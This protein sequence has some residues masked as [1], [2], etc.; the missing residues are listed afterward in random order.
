MKKLFPSILISI[1]SLNSY[2]VLAHNEHAKSRFVAPQG[3][4]NSNCANA[5]HPCKS[6]VYAVKKANK[7]DKIKVAQGQY[8]ITNSEELFYLKDLNVPILGGYNRLDH[9][10]NQNYAI[11]PTVLT[12]V[13]VDMAKDLRQRGFSVISDGKS[14]LNNLTLNKQPN[15]F[16]TLNQKQTPQNCVNGKAG[17]FDCNNLDLLAHIP[18]T[19]FSTNPSTANDIWGHVDLNTGKEYAIIGL[20]NGVAVVDV[21]EPT[22]PIE[23][24]TVTGLSSI[25]RDIKVYQY[26]DSELGIWQAYAYA[27]I[28][29]APD[30]VSIIDL[31]DLPNSVT[32][33]NKSAVVSTAH[34]VYISN[35][36]HTFNIALPDLTPSLQLMGTNLNGGA[37][38]NYSLANPKTLTPLTGQVYGQ[39]YTHDGASLVI[40]DARKNNICPSSNMCTIFI[41]FNEKEMK[42]WNITDPQQTSLIGIGTYNDV[43]SVNQY[44]HSGWASED[45]Q[46]IFVHDEFD[47]EKAG[48]NTT[49]RIFSIADLSNPL[50]VGQWTGSTPAID[51]NGFV[52]GNRYYMTNYERGLTVL[53]ISD[54][55]FP[56]EVGFFDTFIPS[57]NADFNGAW[58]T[59]PFLPSGN[60]LVSDFNSGLYILRDNTLNSPQGKISFTASSVNVDQGNNVTVLVQRTSAQTL[61]NTSVGYE[62]LSGSATANNDYT[63]FKGRLNWSE[64]DSSNKEIIISVAD[65]DT[66]GELAES[67]FVRLYD[68]KNGATLSSPSYIKINIAGAVNTGVVNFVN[69]ELTVDENQTTANIEVSRTGTTTGDISVT[70]TL[71]A[72]SAE[73]NTDVTSNAGSNNGELTWADGDSENKIITLTI[74]NDNL[75]ESDENFT[76]NLSSQNGSRIGSKPQSIITILDDDSNTAP[77]VTLGE[78]FQANTG[79]AINLTAT[80]A[81]AENDVLTYAWSQTF[82]NNVTLSATDSANVNFV[83]TTAGTLTF[84][85]T[86]TDSK[87][88]IATDS[89]DVN[90]IAPQPVT[91]MP[92]TSGGSYYYL[93]LLLVLVFILKPK[94]HKKRK[95]M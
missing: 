13:P 95:I 22:N 20:R 16:K 31:N 34:N 88:L 86:V 64:N 90:V 73:L 51:H 85:V 35:I 1:L 92:K 83:T 66:G 52:R 7:G 76:I 3:I 36:D 67:F 23:V 55:I 30:Q 17:S 18:L 15:N 28:D 75:D 5:L 8:A 27:T 58:G 44:V 37:F 71:T 59:Y 87:G 84:L 2:N 26:Y 79:Q 19:G 12:G 24:G 10:K 82:G 39:G 42:L 61:N 46:Y 21:S 32:L 63:S 4:D 56:T 33:A 60:I 80:A 68:P 62:I 81:D 11:N 74:I 50:H 40:D 9:F 41:D 69:S 53:D 54:P 45:N 72:G 91:T 47:E 29:N 78:N 6:I 48:I 57:N 65:N 49:V 38:T 70:Y 43:A 77:T 89:I 25:W 14:Y 93:L 94:R